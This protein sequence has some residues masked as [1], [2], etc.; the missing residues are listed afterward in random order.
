LRET[1]E[2][3]R[4]LAQRT[5]AEGKVLTV[6]LEDLDKN[7]DFLKLKIFIIRMKV[8][9]T[10]TLG[11]LHEARG[12][13]NSAV[14]TFENLNSSI[15]TQNRKLEKI[16]NINSAEYKAWTEKLR[17]GAYSTI[18]GTTVGCIIADVLGAFGICSAINAG[19]SGSTA[20]GIETEILKKLTELEE[21]KAITD[22]ML[23]SVNNFD[24]TIHKAIDFLTD[25]I[26]L[27]NNWSDSAEVVRKNIDKYPEE[28]LRK[29]I[30]IRIYFKYEL[31]DLRTLAEKLLTQPR[32]DVIESLQEEEKNIRTFMIELITLQSV[33]E[34]LQFEGNYLPEYI[35]TKSSLNQTRHELTELARRTVADVVRDL[36]VLLEDLDEYSSPVLYKQFLKNSLNLD[37]LQ[38][39]RVKYETGVK[40]LANLVSFILTQNRQLER[41]LE[42]KDSADYREWIQR[43]LESGNNLKE[44]LNVASD[45]LNDE[46]EQ[47][48]I[49][50][51]SAKVVS[52]NIDIYPK[53]VIIEFESIRIIFENALDDLKNVAGKFKYLI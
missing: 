45:A 37:K 9:M 13:Y 26:D 10:K 12:K 42:R 53:E 33:F 6:L 17:A 18:A 2:E 34:E 35:E 52:R 50:T 11:T 36:K 4:E 1:R 40:T 19:I 38:E 8:F 32:K 25:A 39:A 27:I 24:R 14:E 23:E 22:R 51:K 47:I 48:S 31:D 49:W 43:L 15:A 46:I 16:T 21:M 41:I 5:V 28:F 29:Y 7:K 44:T 20:V 30:S 3:F